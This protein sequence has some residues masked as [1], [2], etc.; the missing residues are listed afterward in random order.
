MHP[1]LA[2]FEPLVGSWTT[3]ATHPEFDG[4]VTGRVT[5]EPLEGGRYLLWRG[6][7]DHE[8]FPDSLWVIGPPESGDGLVAE[9]FDSRGVRRTYEVAVEDGVVR[10][11]RDHPGFEQRFTLTP[12]RD[13]VT[14]DTQLAREPGAFRD[15]LRMR[16]TRAD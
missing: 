15:D 4:V 16:L 14:F 2:A 6:V 13:T 7:C 1:S 12:A 5:F 3:E 10:M 11:W 9:Y 8:L